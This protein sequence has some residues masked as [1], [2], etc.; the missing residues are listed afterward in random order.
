M[1]TSHNQTVD[2]TRLVLINAIITEYK[3]NI[4]EVTAKELSAACQNDKGILTF[5]CII[6]ALYRRVVVPT[7]PADKYTIEKSS[8]TRKEYMQKMEVADATPIQMV[9][10]TP[11]TSEQAESSALAGAQP[12]PAATTQATLV[13][14]TVPTPAATP[15][16][17]DSRQSTPDSPLGSAPTTPPSLPPDRSEEA[18]PF[19][20]L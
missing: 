7:H 8:W 5:P 9:M 6:S 13:T 4:G 15:G 18:I 10:P 1:P 17:P 3:F 14:S 19:H 12:S 20:I 16:T 11:P 2:R